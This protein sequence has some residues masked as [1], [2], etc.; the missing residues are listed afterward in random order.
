MRCLDA[1]LLPT[2]S[3]HNELPIGIGHLARVR[4]GRRHVHLCSADGNPS[5]PED[6]R[7]G[8]GACVRQGGRGLLRG[9][10][11]SALTTFCATRFATAWYGMWQA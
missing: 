1:P 9:R 8:V 2:G 10:D 6:R 11:P 5:L 7:V 3:V 4:D